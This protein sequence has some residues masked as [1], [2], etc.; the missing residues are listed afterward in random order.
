MP[1]QPRPGARRENVERYIKRLQQLEEIACGFRGVQKAYAIQAGRELRVIINSHKIR[2]DA[3]PKL[4]RDIARRIEDEVAYPG[5]VKV[6]TIREMRQQ[7]V[8]R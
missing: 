3:L 6:T 2:D 1:F 8:A 7:A 5:E 4:A